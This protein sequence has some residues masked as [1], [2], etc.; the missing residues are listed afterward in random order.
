MHVIILFFLKKK[1]NFH[2][3]KMK[4]YTGIQKESLQ[5]EPKCKKGSSKEK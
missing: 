4:E 5:K 2:V 1:L 3:E